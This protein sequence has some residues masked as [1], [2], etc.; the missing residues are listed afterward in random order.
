MNDIFVEHRAELYPFVIN[1]L[2]I[3][4]AR[5]MVVVETNGD[6]TFQFFKVAADPETIS[7]RSINS[8]WIERMAKVCDSLHARTGHVRTSSRKYRKDASILI[9]ISLVVIKFDCEPIVRVCI[10]S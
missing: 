5:S 3:L 6:L 10:C 9:R 2:C 7:E 1:I 4:V 8:S